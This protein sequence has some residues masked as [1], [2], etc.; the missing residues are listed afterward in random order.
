MTI[1]VLAQISGLKQRF[2]YITAENSKMSF[3]AE[4]RQDSTFVCGV[5]GYMVYAK[6]RYKGLASWA[7][8]PS[9]NL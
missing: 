9:A 5:V 1:D 8:S 6:G 2:C 3:W 4:G 7:T